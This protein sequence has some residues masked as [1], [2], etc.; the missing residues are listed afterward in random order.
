[1]LS[2]R[3][4][5]PGAA[6]ADR[7]ASLRTRATSREAEPGS[8]PAIPRAGFG[9]CAASPV[10]QADEC[11]R[12]FSS[13]SRSPDTAGTG[14]ILWRPFGAS[15]RRQPQ[16]QGA[17]VAA[18]SWVLSR[19][20]APALPSYSSGRC[21]TAEPHPFPEWGSLSGRALVARGGANGAASQLLP[22]R[23]YQQASLRRE[24]RPYR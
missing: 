5:R 21:S 4:T 2:S 3:G 22:A 23:L 20:E 1:M 19:S 6:P 12:H 15:R 13:P 24:V 17:R 11:R 10:P 14:C 16:A 8:H 9:A 7:Q 18:W